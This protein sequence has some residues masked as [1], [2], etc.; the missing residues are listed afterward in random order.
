[1]KYTVS[2]SLVSESEC[3][4]TGDH[5]ECGE[6]DTLHEA[7]KAWDNWWPPRE[8]VWKACIENGTD[9]EYSLQIGVWDERGENVEL[10]TEP[11]EI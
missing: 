5:W 3:D 7:M 6:Y 2:A 1:M 11:V 10:W 4:F 8:Q 9:D